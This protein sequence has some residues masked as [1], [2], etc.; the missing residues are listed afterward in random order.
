MRLVNL[1]ILL[2]SVMI[3]GCVS[4]DKSGTIT[5]STASIP[6]ISYQGELAKQ[7][8]QL[9]LRKFNCD[10]GYRVSVHQKNNGQISLVYH[11]DKDTFADMLMLKDGLYRNSLDNLRWHQ[12]GNQAT[13]FYPDSQY[14]STK[15][16]WQVTCYAK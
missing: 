4:T 5:S 2:I 7:V 11:S 13:L 8:S 9:S 10:N 15:K 1:S 12:T 3:T 16:V 14:M 6:A